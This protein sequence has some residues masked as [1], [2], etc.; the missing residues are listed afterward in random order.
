MRLFRGECSP[1]YNFSAFNNLSLN[2]YFVVTRCVDYGIFVG[3]NSDYSIIDVPSLPDNITVF[4]SHVGIFHKHSLIAFSPSTVVI[5][6]KV[7]KE[8]S[9]EK[10]SSDIVSAT[11]RIL[12]SLGYD[13]VR[14]DPHGRGNDIL[15]KNKKVS[16]C[17]L[18]K[19]RETHDYFIAFLQG[20]IDSKL[21][22]ILECIRY[23]QVKLKGKTIM[24]RVG[25]LDA[26][27]GRFDAL[28]ES[29][30]DN[31][32]YRLVEG[33]EITWGIDDSLLISLQ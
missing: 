32:G 3:R 12:D 6:A 28:C 14:R 29:I 23:P 17:T 24:E 8:N 25:G 31:W 4:T 9:I 18:D 2:E 20:D 13:D 5:N 26:L 7:K 10:S 11:L 15:Y 1:V 30:K 19:T 33:G 22:E 16:G 21:I 27:S